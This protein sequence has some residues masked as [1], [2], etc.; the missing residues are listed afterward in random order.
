MVRK[1]S[2]YSW[3]LMSSIIAKI[4]RSLDPRFSVNHD[5]F[6]LFTK[7]VILTIEKLC[8]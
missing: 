1:R 2:Y 3:F 5:I 8:L 7:L 4:F 6:K